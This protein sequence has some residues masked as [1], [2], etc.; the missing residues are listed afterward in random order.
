MKMIL[1]VTC[2]SLGLI[3]VARNE[4][5]MSLVD[6]Q[7]ILEITRIRCLA[8][9]IPKPALQPDYTAGGDQRDEI[10]KEAL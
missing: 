8:N 6:V 5:E 3:E 7:R 9:C 4:Y 10:S 1:P 2:S